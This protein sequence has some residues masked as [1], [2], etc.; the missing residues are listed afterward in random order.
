M[1]DER[2]SLG[3]DAAQPEAKQEWERIL[4]EA[5]NGVDSGTRQPAS[6]SQSDPELWDLDAFLNPDCFSLG[7][8]G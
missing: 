7:I 4:E 6:G 3:G 8:Y 1:A 2:V 5:L